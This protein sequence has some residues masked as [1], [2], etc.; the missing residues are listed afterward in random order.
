VE[1]TQ[2]WWSIRPHF[3]FGTVEVRICDA[4]VTAAESER[5]AALIVACVAQA[6]RDEDEGL[7][8]PAPERRFV[9]ENFWRA[10]RFGLDGR[11]IDLERAE[12]EPAAATV[13]RLLA[14]CA[15]ARA[16]LRVDAE[17]SGANG[18]QRQ[19]A[20]HHEGASLRETFAATVAE[21]LQTYAH[22]ERKQ[23]IRIP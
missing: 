11:F 12:E 16:E 5:L 1:Y 9:E 2:V 4:Q 22:P 18:A 6:A 13:E 3:S 17:P 8:L 19:R 14:W 15:P 7:P 20:L 10:I 23:E 21:S